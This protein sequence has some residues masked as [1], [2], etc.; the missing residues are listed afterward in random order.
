MLNPRN[1]NRFAVKIM[2]SSRKWSA[3]TS[4]GY[5]AFI[6]KNYRDDTYYW[7]VLVS[8]KDLLI[9]ANA[10]TFQSDVDQL[11]FSGMLS[12]AYTLF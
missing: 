2:A 9:V 12:L 11:V 10:A 1:G 4:R 3:G 5:L 6:A 8:F 7:C